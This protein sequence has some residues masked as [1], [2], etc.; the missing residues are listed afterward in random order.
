VSSRYWLST[1]G[2]A[3]L[4]GGCWSNSLAATSGPFGAGCDWATDARSTACCGAARAATLVGDG[5][6]HVAWMTPPPRP[7]GGHDA[8]LPCHCGLEL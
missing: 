2:E 8:Q 7:C 1:S 4:P 3:A 5:A 6:R